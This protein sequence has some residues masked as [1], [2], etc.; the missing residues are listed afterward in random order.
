MDERALKEYNWPVQEGVWKIIRVADGPLGFGMYRNHS[1][2]DRAS[3]WPHP[4]TDEC[5][6]V[7][8]IS[9]PMSKS[10]IN[11]FYISA[12]STDYL[13]VSEADTK[14]AYDAL[15]KAKFEINV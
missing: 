12:F 13:F 4:P 8:S 11:L 7:Y 10:K 2:R 3:N 14:R 6:I 9:D 5:G 15:K 1:R